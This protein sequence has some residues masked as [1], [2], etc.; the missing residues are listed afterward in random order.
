MKWNRILYVDCLDPDVGLP[1]LPSQS[2]DL[3]LLDP[4]FGVDLHKS[5][6]KDRKYLNGRILK[7]KPAELLYEDSWR[8]EWN[9]RWFKQVMRVCKAGIIVTAQKR[10]IWWCQNTTPI[11][12]LA[13]THPN[14]YSS[15]KTSRWNKWS[16]YLVYGKLNKRLFSNTWEFIIQWGFLSDG[17][18]SHPSRKGIFNALR[19]LQETETKTMLDCFVGGGSYI[20]AAHLLGIKWIGYEINRKYAKFI[21]SKFWSKETLES[22]GYEDYEVGDMMLL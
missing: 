1:S 7:G 9:L 22:L 8:P 3:A 11:G 6:I 21:Q 18:P 19:I 16:P 2:I 10:L 20:W 14:G 17:K 4:P 13:I 5:M 15:S 12:I